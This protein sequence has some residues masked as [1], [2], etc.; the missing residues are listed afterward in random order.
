MPNSK[1]TSTVVPQQAL[2][3][4]NS[5]MAIDVARRVLARPEV[6]NSTHNLNKIFNIYRIIFQR[7]PNDKE[8]AMALGFVGREIKEE[9][10]IAATAKE[11]ADKA[12][13]D[14]AD[15]EKR[16]MEMMGNSD[17][18]RAIRNTGKFV[19]RTPLTAWETY[20]QALLL[21]NEAAYV[22]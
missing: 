19:E 4:M 2:Y 12:G 20:T 13:K 17:G 7:A 5:P 18:V 1:R 16:S 6:M 8:I 14:A 9:P 15:R 21:S 11:L 10:K 3:L 22:N